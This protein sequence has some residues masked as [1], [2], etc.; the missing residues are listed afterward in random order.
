MPHKFGVEHAQF[1]DENT[2]PSHPPS[3][4]AELSVTRNVPLNQSSK[5]VW[6]IARLLTV[7]L[8]ISH[9]RLGLD[10]VAETAFS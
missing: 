3:A 2:T 8:R 10:C 5:L 1:R 4:R 9:R 6:I 7:I